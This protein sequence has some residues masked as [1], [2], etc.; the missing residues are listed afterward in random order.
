MLYHHKY[1][2]PQKRKTDNP[3]RT[4]TH[5]E[6]LSKLPDTADIDPKL[7]AKAIA[8]SYSE[9]FDMS[10]FS[11]PKDGNRGPVTSEAVIEAV[12]GGMEEMDEEGFTVSSDIE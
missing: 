12:T 6:I 7:A 5:L 2:R 10:S 1:Y 3:Q 9:N 8:Q 11:E 4:K